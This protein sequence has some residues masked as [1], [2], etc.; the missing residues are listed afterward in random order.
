MKKDVKK[1]LEPNTRKT[2]PPAQ[3]LRAKRSSR[4]SSGRQL[5]HG[6]L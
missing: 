2:E 5:G 3:N 4:A 1:E 6:P